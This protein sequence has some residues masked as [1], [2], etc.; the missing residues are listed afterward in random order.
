MEEYLNRN[1][2]KMKNNQIAK[3]RLDKQIYNLKIGR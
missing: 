2:Y 1:K 3:I